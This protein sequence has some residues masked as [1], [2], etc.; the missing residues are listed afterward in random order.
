M[1]NKYYF[2]IVI[3][4]L[5]CFG[6]DK[7]YSNS[8]NTLFFI[9]I[10][11]IE[12]LALLFFC[13]RT[14]TFPTFLAFTL[15]FTFTAFPWLTL[16]LLFTWTILLLTAW[17]FFLAFFLLFI[18]IF[19]FTFFIFFWMFMW[20]LLAFAFFLVFFMVTRFWFTCRGFRRWFWRWSHWGGW[21]GWSWFRFWWGWRIF[22]FWMPVLMMMMMP[23]S[24]STSSRTIPCPM[25]YPSTIKANFR[26]MR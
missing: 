9:L 22:M 19:F 4:S 14:S 25:S 21:W 7:I 26:A 3:I 12:I 6:V 24:R 10:I 17:A 20:M 2:K 8:I 13:T 16:T 5:F 11:C 23:M 1:S 15:T 18:L